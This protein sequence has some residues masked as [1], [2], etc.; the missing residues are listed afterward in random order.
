MTSIVRSVV[1]RLYARTG[2]AGRLDPDIPLS[3]LL[4]EVLRRGM[5]L[6]HC[7][8]R[9]RCVG[10]LG[11]HVKIRD[12]RRLRLGRYVVIGDHS[13]IDCVG[14]RGVEL[15]DWVSI[16]RFSTVTTTGHLSRLGVGLKVGSG[17]GLGEF[18]HLGSAGGIVIGDDVIVGPYVSF[19]SQ[20]HVISGDL[21]APIKSRGTTSAGIEIGDACWIGAKCTIL[22]GV[23]LG[24]GS[25][26]AAG[27]VVKDEF[28]P[29]SVIAGVP[30]RVI[31][32]VEE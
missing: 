7:L 11:R 29:R 3:A 21:G 18:C 1:E 28:P 14:T 10:F 24:A 2:R 26:V 17:S 27:S 16:G 25:V 19:H 8:T 13:L 15:G 20:E 5:S 12:R 23:R 32:S 22:D 31:R 30:A 9:L 4:S 6:L